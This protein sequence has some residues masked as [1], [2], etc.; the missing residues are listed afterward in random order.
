MDYYNLLF[1][2]LGKEWCIVF[3][4]TVLILGISF[5]AL[6]ASFLMKV[7]IGRAS[8]LDA[9]MW[10]KLAISFLG[11]ITSRLYLTMCVR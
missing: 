7:A 1:G 9:D 4:V 11:Y 2:T 5:F 6:L 3:R 8:L 10:L